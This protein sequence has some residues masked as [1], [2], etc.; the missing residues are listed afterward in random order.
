MP[1][2]ALFFENADKVRSRYDTVRQER[3]AS[4][5]L[6]N[7]TYMRR[8]DYRAA[9]FPVDLPV[10]LTQGDSTQA[11]RCKEISTEGMKVEL[12]EPFSPRSRG[13][14]DLSYESLILK[15]P[16][17]VVRS[18]L[19][20]NSIQFIY[21]SKEQRD[22]MACLVACLSHPRPCRSLAMVRSYPSPAVF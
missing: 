21:E 18:E 16:F 17:W 5:I 10:C 9:R 1:H 11:A 13:T 7:R 4:E 2:S 6:S 8:F 22:A 20:C 12:S 19:N 3:F 15:V 14:V